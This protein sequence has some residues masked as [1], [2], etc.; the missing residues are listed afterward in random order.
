[1]RR[2]RHIRLLGVLV[3]AALL[4]AVMGGGQ[5]LAQGTPPA[6]VLPQSFWGSVKDASGNSILSGTVEAW[7]NG[8]K[9]D[10]IAIVNGQY[11]G[12]GGFDE[13]LIVQGTSEDVG[14]TIEFYV[15]GV[16]AN[17]TAKYTPGEKTMVNLTVAAPS[18]TTPPAVESTDP[19]NGAA[20]VAVDKAI[21][22]T[23]GE[24]VLAGGAY[25][26][27]S[28]K[29][30]AGG[31]VAVTKSIAGKVLSI[32]PNA[33]L[34]YG[35]KYTVTIPASAVKDLAGNALAQ[36]YTFSFTTQAAPDT[37][38]P[39]VANTDP[40][41]N[42]TSV[43]VSKTISVTF[44]EDVQ[45]GTAYDAIS[46]KDVNSTAVA[47]TKSIAGK[48]L[49][50][51]PNASLAYGAKYTVTIPASAV[52]DL[53]GNALAQGYTFSFT[54]QAASGGGGGGGGGGGA[55]APST[56]K[57]EK[58]V[59]A[60]ATTV[61]EIS[62][63]VKVEVPAG[64][65]TGANAIIKTEVMGD[66]KASGAGLT[67]LSKVVDITLKNGTLAGKIT[68]TLYFDKGKLGKDQEPAAFCYD[69][70]GGKWV[71]LG[72]N[73]DAD[74][75]TV[76]VTVDHLTMFAVFAVAKEAP[77]P[78][79]VS[80]K[81]M[82][83]H[84]AA[85]TVGRLAAMEIVSGYPD[86]TFKPENEITRAE[87][88]AILARA[89]KLAPGKAEDLNFADSA[90]IPAWAKGVVAAAAKEGL[91][92]GY[93]QP[94]GTLTFKADR[95]LSRVEMAALAVRILEK[96]VGKVTPAELKFAD[97][98]AIPGWAKTS[99]GVAV[100]KGIVV[101]YPDNTFRPDKPVTRV[102]AAAMIFR[103]LDSVGNK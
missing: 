102:E 49:S 54:T 77:K 12:P 75:G 91:V 72:G 35:A 32:R 80:F 82:Q 19:T 26:G 71:R 28:L 41:N 43:P 36:G 70:K 57:V 93:P 47:V 23:F 14:K 44:S 9:Q 63:K 11:G 85:E 2:Q 27:I 46:L 89:L 65:V 8:V 99:V 58:P 5:A 13:R 97:A 62:G 95:P 55:A 30:A 92:K 6:P 15:N 39:A 88:T 17:E 59:Q 40:A 103:L 25:D 53:A 94:D 31:A 100:A 86:G 45:Q 18:D 1:M 38:P 51:R 87:V 52:K 83:G 42:A 96:K 21:T 3:V 64:A 84:W 16:K 79:V 101:G 33:S 7:M 24:D 60:G 10:S 69:E 50:I 61:A 73:V 67:L 4:L 56:D 81:D 76:T 78:S 90:A 22:V 37:T 98:G 48:V 66:D 20:N 74:K 68:I 34:A 29:D